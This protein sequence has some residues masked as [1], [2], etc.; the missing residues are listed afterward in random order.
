M[1]ADGVTDG[2]IGCRLRVEA[3]EAAVRTFEPSVVDVTEEAD[4][5]DVGDDAEAVAVVEAEEDEPLPDDEAF[6]GEEVTCADR[7]GR[8]QDAESCAAAP[9]LSN[10]SLTHGRKLWQRKFV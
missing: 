5:V 3:L 9:W 10:M 4:D 2:A 7:K 8:A 6:D 1:I